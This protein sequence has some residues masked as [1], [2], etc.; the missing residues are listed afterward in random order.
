MVNLKVESTW[1]NMNKRMVISLPVT[2]EVSVRDLLT[3]MLIT[4]MMTYIVDERR[5]ILHEEFDNEGSIL[6]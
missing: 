6:L 5:V 1:E 2:N 3:L 4:D